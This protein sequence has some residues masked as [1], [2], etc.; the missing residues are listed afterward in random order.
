MAM[1]W[2]WWAVGIVAVLMVGGYQQWKANEPVEPTEASSVPQF[3]S[4]SP[5]WIAKG[6]ST[7]D[8]QVRYYNPYPLAYYNAFLRQWVPD[9]HVDLYAYGDT[10]IDVRVTSEYLGYGYPAVNRTTAHGHPWL[11][12]ATAVEQVLPLDQDKLDRLD[13]TTTFTLHV[14]VETLD[15]RG[16]ATLTYDETIP[17]EVLPTNTAVLWTKTPAT[18][19]KPA[20][21]VSLH[22]Y[23]ASFVQPTNPA[24]HELLAVAKEYHPQRTLLGMQCPGCNDEQWN[25]VITEQVRAIYD[26]LAD[27]YGVSYLNMPTAFGTQAASAQ[28]V[29]T[30]D[31]SLELASANCLD[32]SIL[33]ASALEALGINPYI[34]I[35]PGHAYIAYDWKPN[36]PTYIGVETTVVGQGTFDDA[37]EIGYAEL[38]RDV[39]LI[40][41]DDRYFALDIAALRD[42][43]FLPMI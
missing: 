3:E 1:S 23:L 38:D 37:L 30:P 6:N 42:L 43:G 15:K 24:V 18:K 29:N 7:L 32:G 22:P 28:R 36:S 35:I 13:T 10:D 5:S 11:P 40:A 9:V 31:E 39:P 27:H 21:W 4:I 34:I 19:D 17:I 33:F 25:M 12:Q 41:S 14:K 20:E 16:V 8:V 2:R 26:A